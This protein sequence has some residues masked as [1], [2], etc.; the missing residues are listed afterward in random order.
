MRVLEYGA[1]LFIVFSWVL[2]EYEDVVEISLTEDVEMLVE[3]GH[4]R[5]ERCWGI[6]V[7]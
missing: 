6:G 4:E 1:D 7:W 3:D 5:L 2:R